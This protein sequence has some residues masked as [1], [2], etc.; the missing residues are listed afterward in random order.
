MRFRKLRIAWS[1]V[2]GL[3]AVLLCVLWV[4]SYWHSDFVTSDKNP[5][6]RL[7]TV[8][9]RFGTTILVL[10]YFPMDSGQSHWRYST[11]PAREIDKLFKWTSDD[12]GL[13]VQVP[14]FILAAI[15]LAIGYAPWLRYHF[16]L[17]TLLIATTLI[18]LVL[19]LI[20]WSLR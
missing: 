18:A 1:V 11:G 8:G 16:S 19:G 3:L 6:N 5:V 12:G 10:G 20:V 7:I 13:V 9:S 4:R 17:R 15:S 14:H 2:W